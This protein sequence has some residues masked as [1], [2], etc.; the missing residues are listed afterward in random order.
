MRPE[1]SLLYMADVGRSYSVRSCYSSA[2]H[3]LVL[4]EISN[5]KDFFLRQFYS[6]VRFSKTL[7]PFNNAVLD[8]VSLRPLKKVIWVD[9]RRV[10]TFVAN[11]IPG[12]D[13]ADIK[14]V[15]V[16]VRQVLPAFSGEVAVPVRAFSPYPLNALPLRA[17]RRCLGFETAN[18]G[19]VLLRGH[20]GER[21]FTILAGSYFH[22]PRVHWSDKFVNVFN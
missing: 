4:E 10:V 7:A 8:V 15:R 19:A 12:K 13:R 1:F 21:L 17:I 20:A 11:Y 5:L 18:L 14:C 22:I 3:R 6:G 2:F 16:S 9:A